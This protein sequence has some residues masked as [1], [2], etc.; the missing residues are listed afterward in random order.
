MYSLFLLVTLPFYLSSIITYLDHSRPIYTYLT[1]AA[2]LNS[3]PQRL[4]R[5]SQNKRTK[6]LGGDANGRV[7]CNGKTTATGGDGADS[8]FIVRLLILRYFKPPTSRYLPCITPIDHTA[9]MSKTLVGHV[10]ICQQKRNPSL[11]SML[12]WSRCKGSSLLRSG[13]HFDSLC[14]ATCIAGVVML[15][16]YRRR[17]LC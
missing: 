4:H 12:P 15:R 6:H 16:S 9:A 1:I 14:P 13:I 11:I 10:N 17:R 2:R 8:W 3:S 5:R 7:A